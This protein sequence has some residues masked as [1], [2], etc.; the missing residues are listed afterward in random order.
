[1]NMFQGALFMLVSIF[2]VGVLYFGVVEYAV[3]G[4]LLPSLENVVDNDNI[5]VGLPSEDKATIHDNYYRIKL[6]L[7]LMPFVLFFVAMLYGFIVAIRKEQ[8]SQYGGMY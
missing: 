2:G 7:R 4:H 6:Y 5:G 1:M 3:I 8:E